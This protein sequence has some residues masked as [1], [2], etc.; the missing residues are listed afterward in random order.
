MKP[1][2]MKRT[3]P[4]LEECA[5]CGNL[6]PALACIAKSATNDPNSPDIRAIDDRGKVYPETWF[7]PLPSQTRIVQSRC[8]KCGG[9]N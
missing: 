7:I 1:K 5:D 4:E 3:R 8:P 6:Y 9:W 2:W